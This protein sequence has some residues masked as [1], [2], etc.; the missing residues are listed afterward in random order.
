MINNSFQIN[1]LYIINTIII[2]RFVIFYKIY[3]LSLPFDM[4]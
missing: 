4:P 2:S 3:S 1:F